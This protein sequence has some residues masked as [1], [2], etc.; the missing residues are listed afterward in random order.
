ME[1]HP[2][3]SRDTRLLIV[4]IAVSIVMLLVLARFRFPARP[5]PA[6]EPPPQPLERL[7]AR[8]TYDEL[9]N[10]LRGVDE[11]VSDSVVAVTIL[12]EDQMN[13]DGPSSRVS[14]VAVRLPG[15][16][17]VT[18]T[19]AG[20]RIDGTA[21]RGGVALVASDAALGLSLLNLTGPAG[22]L[23]DVADA[24]AARQGP[25]YLAAIE[26]TPAGLAVRPM[27]F[28]RVD[29]DSEPGWTTPLMR[30]SAL[31]QALPSGA[32]IFTLRGGFIGLGVPEGRDL[33]VV[34]ASALTRAADALAISRPRALGDPGFQVQALDASLRQATDAND[35]VIVSYVAPDGPSAK[36]LRIG[37]IITGLGSTV[38]HAPGDYHAAALE[39]VEGSP[40]TVRFV[41][42]RR[43]ATAE[44]TPSA[45]LR[46]SSPAAVQLG[47]SLRRAHDGSEVTRVEPGSA[48]ARAG[49]A[50]GD[51]ITVL[52]DT[53]QP[54]PASIVRAFQQLPSGGWLVVGLDRSG[55]HLVTAIGKP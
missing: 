40:V 46:T 8:A 19:T 17:A 22:P 2:R 10:I 39:L 49:V 3:S 47:L 25:G 41:R 20:R 14:V 1:P 44:I 16:R 33:I 9:T 13:P 6:V 27:Y 38:I 48:A 35:G 29:A 5:A 55:T 11:R 54:D 45:R 32:A 28:G 4:T 31:Q 52:I 26:N 21:D 34:P 42:D 12:T 15:G 24:E 50:A 23:P 43:P 18:L 37:D 51:I 30:F 7:A 36:A 53:A